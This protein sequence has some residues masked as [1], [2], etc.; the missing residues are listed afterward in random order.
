VAYS[1]GTI[2]ISDYGTNDYCQWI[3]FGKFVYITFS[4][5]LPSSITAGWHTLYGNLPFAPN[6]TM[7]F[8][9]QIAGPMQT[10]IV[11]DASVVTSKQLNIFVDSSVN[12]K[13]VRGTIMYATD[14]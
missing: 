5:N 9:G 8:R 4:V 1:K 3:R 7:Y 13:Q 14:E 2:S 12:G 6:Q 10:P 11:C